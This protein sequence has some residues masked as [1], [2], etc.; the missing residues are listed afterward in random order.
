[1]CRVL[2]V[3]CHLSISG[4]AQWGFCVLGSPSVCGSSPL[5]LQVGKPCPCDLVIVLPG[6]CVLLLLA[7]PGCK[8]ICGV[9]N[10]GMGG[11]GYVGW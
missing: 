5:C 8:V 9:K 4:E 2:E 10:I 1:M 6:T 11:E 3:L 7:S